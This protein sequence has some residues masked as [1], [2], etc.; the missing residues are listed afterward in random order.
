MLWMLGRVLRSSRFR[1]S[2]NGLVH[3]APYIKALSIELH[4]GTLE[5]LK[6][7]GAYEKNFVR[8]GG[9][10]RASFEKL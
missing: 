3:L 6:E 5:S 2:G 7:K 9:S 1:G 8:R 10:R 4:G